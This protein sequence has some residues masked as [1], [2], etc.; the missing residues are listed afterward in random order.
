MRRFKPRKRM[1]YYVAHYQHSDYQVLKRIFAWQKLHTSGFLAHLQHL[2]QAE[3]VILFGSMTRW[4]WHIQ[5]D[6]DLFIYGNAAGLDVGK[7][8][9]SLGKDIEV[10]ACQD[11][12]ELARYTPGLLKNILKGDFIKGNL[13]FVQVL[14]NGV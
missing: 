9:V 11:H 10:F 7:F 14:P 8:E 4:D 5:S 2:P 12:T 3:T 1:P 6:V 13:D